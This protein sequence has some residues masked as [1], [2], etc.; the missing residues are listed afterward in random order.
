MVAE[1]FAT[2]IRPEPSMHRF[3]IF[4]LTLLVLSVYASLPR[5]AWAAARG[6][7]RANE[8]DPSAATLGTSLEA[9]IAALQKQHHVHGLALALIEHG[10]VAWTKSYGLADVERGAP[11]DAATVFNV[12]SVSKTVTA[13]GVMRLV[14]QDRIDLDAPI[15]AQMESWSLPPSVFDH[16]GVT[17]RRLLSHSAGLSFCCYLGFLLEDP[18]PTLVQSLDGADRLWDQWPPTRGEAVRV[19]RAPGSG[20]LYSGGGYALLQLLIEDVTG[21]RFEDYMMREVLLPLQMLPGG[22]AWT[23]ELLQSAAVPHGEDDQ[24]TPYRHFAATGAAGLQTT[25]RGL[26]H[27]AAAALD[28][29]SGAPAGRGVLRRQTVALMLAPTPGAEMRKDEG[30]VEPLGFGLGYWAERLPGGDRAV[31]HTGSNPGWHAGLWL[32]PARGIGLVVLTNHGNGEVF[33]GDWALRT[34]D[35]WSRSLQRAS[36]EPATPRD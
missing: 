34:L 20:Y 33:T 29:R 6:D 28:A 14:E 35:R 25:V 16:S 22:F 1:T 23:E 21:E 12:G 32:V 26:A 9:E 7:L 36:Q 19:V 5:F 4:S 17:V 27:F 8:F 10:K 13:W 30:Y 2:P 24:P 11:V 31:G 18:L 15:A 3:A